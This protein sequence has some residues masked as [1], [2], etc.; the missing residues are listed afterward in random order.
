MK[1]S[2]RELREAQI[3]SK[4]FGFN[5][6]VVDALLERAADTIEGLIEENRQLFEALERLRSEGAATPAD[7]FADVVPVAEPE[8]VPVVEAVAPAASIDESITK[9]EMS[10]KEDLIN[11][12]LLLAQKTADE[13]LKT[14]KIQADELV[15]TAQASA[16]ELVEKAT[17]DAEALTGSAREQADANLMAAQEQ[18]QALLV[19][20]QTEAEALV[21]TAQEQADSV[22]KEERDKYVALMAKLSQQREQLVSDITLLQGFDLQHRSRL[23]SA[24]EEDLEKIQ[25]REIIDVE[26][27]PELPEVVEA[28]A[29]TK[30][31]RSKTPAPEIEAEVVAHSE[32]K[33]E[34]HATF[35]DMLGVDT[36]KVA[37]ASP[38]DE[39]ILVADDFEADVVDEPTNTDIV[40][41]ASYSNDDP[42]AAFVDAPVAE[43]AS[44]DNI[45]DAEVVSPAGAPVESAGSQNAF[46]PKTSGKKAKQEDIDDDDF[47][48]SLREAVHDD[49]PLGPSDDEDDKG[50]DSGRFKGIFKK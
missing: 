2:P 11:K 21:A 33:V 23:V 15:A 42:F 31:K 16:Q 29:P 7:P 13:T 1:I 46:A 20:A 40:A 10:E 12:T 27:I 48:A 50:D 18:A 45:A 37:P 8:P 9:A 35:D 41:P 32:M 47:F 5:Q 25:G 44:E 30:R 28:P 22:H 36:P 39:D 26:S 4:A 14:A 6:D 19:T 24:I 43:P 17:T 3:P 49:T 38:V 34:E